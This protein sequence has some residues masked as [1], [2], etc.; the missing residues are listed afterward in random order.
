MV[1]SIRDAASKST[2]VP[3]QSQH[4][5]ELAT[6]VLAL[7]QR[8]S[9]I[10]QRLNREPQTTA[11]PQP[12]V[13]KQRTKESE[14]HE[15]KTLTSPPTPSTQP[16]SSRRNSASDKIDRAVNAVMSYND[17]CSTDDQRWAVTESAIARLTGCNRPAIRN[18]FDSHRE[19]IDQHNSRYQFSSRHN[20][21]L[22]RQKRFIEQEISF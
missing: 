12:I 17:N 19:A 7:A 21:K 3:D 1:E 2:I 8:L 14:Q 5:E 18:Y 22:S 15:H 10:E 6:S 16:K 11:P 9:Q 20:A 13:E 4:I